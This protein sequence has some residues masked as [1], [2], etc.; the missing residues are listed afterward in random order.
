MPGGAEDREAIEQFR[1]V[2][3]QF[4]ATEVIPCEEALDEPRFP[5]ELFRRLGELGYLGIRYPEDV[6]GQG[7]GLTTACVLWEELA[8]GSLALAAICAMQGLMGT[9]FVYR[10]GSDE[11][12]EQYLR[13]AVRG[14]KVATFALTEPNAGSDLGAIQCRASKVDGG[15]VINGAKTWISNAPVA[16]FLTVGARTSDEP[17][18]KSIALFF[19]DAS[20]EGFVVGKPIEKLGVRSS[21]TSQVNF[22]DCFVPDSALLGDVGDGVRIVGGILSEI[23][24]MTA[25]L[26]VGLGRRALDAAASYSNEREAFGSRIGDFQAIQHK[27]A[28]MET[29]LFAAKVL[30][31]AVAQRVEAGEATVRET[32]MVKLFASE[33]CAKVVDQVTRIFGS[34]GFAME[35]PAQP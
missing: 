15:W 33:A 21:L 25:A 13:P 5:F 3:R 26:S 27:I 29:E 11:H 16:D 8:Y 30:T 22:D 10:Y 12:H 19:V 1:T 14:E 34:Y 7:A 9:E 23:R 17:G 6:G 32:A 28:D 20:A 24:T 4:V 2:V 18:L 35:Y 31:D